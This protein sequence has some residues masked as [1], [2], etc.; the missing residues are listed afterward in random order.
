[1]VVEGSPFHR[2]GTRVTKCHFSHHSSGHLF[3]QDS[4]NKACRH[5]SKRRQNHDLGHG[6]GQSHL[7]WHSDLNQ[8]R[9]CQA[10]SRGGGFFEGPSAATARSV[11]DSPHLC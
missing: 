4:C 6:P 3:T 2:S 5:L 7:T 10:S 11:V 8:E 9:Y 1:M